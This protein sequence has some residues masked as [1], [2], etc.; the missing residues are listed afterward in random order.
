MFTQSARVYDPLFPVRILQFEDDELQ[1]VRMSVGRVE[2]RRSVIDFHYLIA[3][4]G[5]IQHRT[6]THT[7]GLFTNPVYRSAFERAGLST[8]HDSTGPT[9]RSLWVGQRKSIS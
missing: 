9:G 8:D 4:P 1:V 3:Q 6:E 2:G 7:M 5:Q